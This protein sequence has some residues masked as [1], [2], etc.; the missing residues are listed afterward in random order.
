MKQ[1]ENE[2]LMHVCHSTPIS[3]CLCVLVSPAPQFS[4]PEQSDESN[5]HDSDNER[6]TGRLH[7]SVR[8][9]GYTGGFDNDIVTQTLISGF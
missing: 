4:S 7:D 3:D 2:L 1:I 8:L 6:T 9:K 5:K